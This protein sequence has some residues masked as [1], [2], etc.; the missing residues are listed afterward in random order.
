M[1]PHRLARVAEVIREVASET[2]LFGLRDPRVKGVTVTRAEVSGDL[3]HAKVYVSV[4]GTEKEQKLC[5]HGLR[6]AAGFIQ[7]KVASR[8][9]TR[10]TPVIR[11]V[12]DQ[13]VKKSIEMTR[14]I[15]EALARSPTPADQ[16]STDGTVEEEASDS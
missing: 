6:H 13:G 16:G 5:L 10:F 9:Q 8:L 7:A 14:L 15:K 11:F 4:M 1:K 3:Q 2:I 12:L